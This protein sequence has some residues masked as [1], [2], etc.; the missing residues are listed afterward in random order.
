MTRDVLL[1][2]P[3]V[4]DQL[5]YELEIRLANEIKRVFVPGVKEE[6]DRRMK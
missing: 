4:V 6:L 3:K 1:E 2:C 5:H